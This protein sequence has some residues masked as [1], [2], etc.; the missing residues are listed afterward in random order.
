[1]KTIIYLQDNGIP[2][3]VMPTEEALQEHGIMAIAIKDVPA[4]KPF[5]IVDANDLPTD[6]PQE[7]WVVD[8]A[9]LTD[10]VGGESSEF[11]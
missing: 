3:V 7:A 8:E 1:M 4:G 10:G 6:G 2:A 11:N 9:D 5:K